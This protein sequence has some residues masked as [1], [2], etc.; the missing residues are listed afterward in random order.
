MTDD[1]SD[2]NRSQDP[3]DRWAKYYQNWLKNKRS[4]N[5][6][7]KTPFWQLGVS[8]FCD[9]FL[10]AKKFKKKKYFVEDQAMHIP[11]KFNNHWP[12]GFRE[13]NW[14]AIDY[15]RQQTQSDDN[16]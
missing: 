8:C 5:K 15:G 2:G 11:T 10:I 9:G 7:Q 16:I 14:D 3:L 6:K 13:E 12:S 1:R 4:T